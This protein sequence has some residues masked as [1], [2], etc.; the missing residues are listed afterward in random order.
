VP[1]DGRP[2][3][4][5]GEPVETWVITSRGETLEPQAW[6]ASI[7]FQAS[8]SA[9]APFVRSDANQDGEVNIA[10]AVAAFNKLFRA[11]PLL[12]CR[13]ALDT[14]D[15]EHVDLSDVIYLLIFLYQGG[16]APPPPFTSCG[17]DPSPG[18][19]CR[20]YSSPAC[21]SR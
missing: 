15:D 20:E 14:N 13:A 5:S 3:V 19:G 12:P 8:A 21:C 17:Q 2:L 6:T 16:P 18:P 7:R 11:S 10:D 9:P 1:P 4:G